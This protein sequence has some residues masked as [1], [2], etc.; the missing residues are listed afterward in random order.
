MSPTSVKRS[1]LADSTGKIEIAGSDGT[2]SST[3]ARDSLHS[4]P[5]SNSTRQTTLVAPRRGTI[6]RLRRYE[7]NPVLQ[8]NPDHPWEAQNVS[9]AGAAMYNGK[10]CLLYRAEG[11][12]P[13]IPGYKDWPVGCLG[14]AVSDDGYHFTQRHSTPAIEKSGQDLE[15]F[16]VEDARIARI[17]DTYYITYVCTSY[18]GDH[19]AL[20]TTK[21]FK[22]F[23]KRWPLMPHIS[24]RTAGLFP[25]RIGGRYCLMHRIL[26]SIWLSFSHD[27]QTWT[28]T[29]C[30]LTPKMGTW[31]DWKIGI[32]ATPIERE[33]SWLVFWH[34][35][36]VD[37]NLPYGTYRLGILWLDKDDPR[38]VIRVQEEPILDVEEDY[39]KQGY[40]PNVIYTCGAVEKDG[41]YLVYYGC[42][43]RVLALATVPVD[44]CA[45]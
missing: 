30:I 41:Q 19:I 43:D 29:T 42:C 7:G 18:Y 45:P 40:T 23:T 11:Y 16:A 33:D 24:Q 10:V 32:G 4:A 1:N 5:P 39:E 27:L 36:A 15:Q 28:D 37:G 26:P 8:P 35:K 25:G 14:L 34:A 3:Y 13:K 6:V 21:D 44:E 38:K 20:A 12:E 9:N 17:D 22:T 31:Y 2:L